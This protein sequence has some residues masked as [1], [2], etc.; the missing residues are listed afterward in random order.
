M[1]AVASA[2]GHLHAL[3]THRAWIISDLQQSIPAE[4][5]RC[6][7]AAVEDTRA[8]GLRLDRIWYL[9]DAVEGSDP[10][11]T[12]I[13][14]RMQIAVL[15]S[16]TTPVLFISG[17]HDFDLVAAGKGS[18]PA[19]RSAARDLPN[20]RTTTALD[21]PYL[22][23]ELGGCAIVALSDHCD[24]GGRWL[25]THGRLHGDEAAYPHAGTLPKLR[26]EIAACGKPVI[27]LAHYALPGGNRPAPLFDGLMP[28][29][30]NVRL[31]VHGHAHIGDSVWAGKDCHRKIA[32]VDGHP[33]PQVD[34]ASLEDKRGNSIRS[35]FLELYADGGC[36]VL[37]RDHTARRW[38]DALLLDPA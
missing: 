27:T 24:P 34:I 14:A 36:A 13:M 29:P 7:T 19:L 30:S 35:A 3:A 37:F 10:E 22:W 21:Q 23:D 11:R 33:V 5:E 4:A 17:N 6:L 32:C 8:L 16:L 12:A 28:L 26:A 18:E 1:R 38:S 25:S 15:D 9:G 20:W 31:H 2:I